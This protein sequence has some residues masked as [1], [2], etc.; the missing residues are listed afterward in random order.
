MADGLCLFFDTF[1]GV[2]SLLVG[3]VVLLKVCRLL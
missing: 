2:S 3:Y 1:K